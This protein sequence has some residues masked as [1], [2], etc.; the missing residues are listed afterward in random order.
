MQITPRYWNSASNCTHAYDSDRRAPGPVRTYI[1]NLFTGISLLL[2]FICHDFL[3][4]SPNKTNHKWNQGSPSW[5]LPALAA[6]KCLSLSLSDHL[7]GNTVNGLLRLQFIV[8]YSRAC[9]EKIGVH[10]LNLIYHKLIS[11]II[12]VYLPHTII[13]GWVPVLATISAIH[14]NLCHLL[15]RKML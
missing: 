3:L 2:W 7:S 6:R 15:Y 11:L 4:M 9:V 8:R 1:K 10:I 12:P 5:L 14:V 13:S